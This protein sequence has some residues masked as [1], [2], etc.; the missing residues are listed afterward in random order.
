MEYNIPCPPTP[1]KGFSQF[2]DRVHS[3][4]RYVKKFQR[5]PYPPAPL[6]NHKTVYNTFKGLWEQIPIK[7]EDNVDLRI[8]NFK[9]N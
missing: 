7:D 6:R 4:W 8:N 5:I 1:M 2:Y 3:K 9:C